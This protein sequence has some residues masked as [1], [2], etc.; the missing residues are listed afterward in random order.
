MIDPELRLTRRERLLSAMEATD[1]EAVAI[2]PGANFYYLT[3]ANFHLMERPTV[4]FV[5]RSGAMHAVVPVLEKAR[6]AAL[7]PEVE[8]AYWQDS[9]G[10]ADAFAAAAARLNASRIG[11]EGQRMRVFEANAIR[12][13][14]RDTPVIDAH[15]A[16]SRMRLHKDEA[17]IAA[18]ER[19]IA[20]SEAALADTLAATVAGMSVRA[21][22]GMLMAAM[23][24]HGADGTAFDP[25]V[26]TGAAAADPHGEPSAERVLARS[27]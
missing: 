10:Y 19:A 22:R 1:A 2:V 21:V 6:W 8:T 14:F 16:I 20:I 3:G 23:L 24:E 11:V 18:I 4:L 7:A 12:H 5:T 9:D 13:A 26:L 17:E 15:A 25:I 27:D